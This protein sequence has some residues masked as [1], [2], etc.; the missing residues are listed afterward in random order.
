MQSTQRITILGRAWQETI[1][2]QVGLQV[3]HRCRQILAVERFRDLSPYT[4][5]R[6]LPALILS[7]L[8][9]TDIADAEL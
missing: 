1:T 8:S 2:S 3:D 6:F 9:E 5:Y 4:N 7:F